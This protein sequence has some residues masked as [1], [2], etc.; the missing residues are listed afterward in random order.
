MIY[1]YVYTRNACTNCV[2]TAGKQGWDYLCLLMLFETSDDLRKLHKFSVF[3]GYSVREHTHT[4]TH[5]YIYIYIYRRLRTTRVS[6]SLQ[7]WTVPLQPGTGGDS[8]NA[9]TCTSANNLT[10]F[11]LRS[12]TVSRNEES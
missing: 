9:R 11:Q 5:I 3:H 2:C 10:L 6:I 12:L 1:I 7:H 8:F 4:H